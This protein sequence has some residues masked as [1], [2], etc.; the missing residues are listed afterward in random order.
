MHFCDDVPNYD[1]DIYSSLGIDE[2]RTQCHYISFPD[3]PLFVKSLWYAKI[4]PSLDSLSGE[5]LCAT[6]CEGHTYD[7]NKIVIRAV[8]RIGGHF[9]STSEIIRDLNDDPVIASV[10]SVP[11]LPDDGGS[12]FDGISYFLGFAANEITTK[13]KL[14]NPKNKY[15]AFVEHSLLDIT[16]SIINDDSRADV[17]RFKEVFTRHVK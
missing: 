8:M 4:M 16:M 2:F 7:R 14:S 15:W 1:S 9:T 17:I 10:R 3:K 13:I 6:F 12:T 5:I 11:L